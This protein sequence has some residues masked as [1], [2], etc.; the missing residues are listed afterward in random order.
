[1]NGLRLVRDT[2]RGA[3]DLGVAL[4]TLLQRNI[5]DYSNLTVRRLSSTPAW[6]M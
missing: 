1:M 5:P 3:L 4:K 6:E 2:E